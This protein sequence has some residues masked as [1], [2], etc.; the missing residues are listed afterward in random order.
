VIEE[1]LVSDIHH[2]TKTGM[3]P[4]TKNG[5]LKFLQVWSVMIATKS[6]EQAARAK[7][8]V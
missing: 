7:L 4:F 1:K 6:L 5:N 8:S 2:G 3:R